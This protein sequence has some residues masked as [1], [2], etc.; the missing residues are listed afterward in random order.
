[1]IRLQTP[2]SKCTTHT[3]YSLRFTAAIPMTLRVRVWVLCP[4]KNVFHV[5]IMANHNRKINRKVQSTILPNSCC[6]FVAC[7]IPLTSLCS[8]I[9]ENNQIR[10]HSIS[11]KLVL[12]G[13]G[14][15]WNWKR[16]SYS[17]EAEGRNVNEKEWSVRGVLLLLILLLLLFIFPLLLLLLLLQGPSRLLHS[18][19]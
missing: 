11:M 12:C 7:A 8:A 18:L 17:S 5:L 2:D 14:S 4:C 3:P 6:R 10:P 13:K 16:V 19:H 9:A 15:G 1:M